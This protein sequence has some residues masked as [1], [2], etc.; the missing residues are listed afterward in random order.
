MSRVGAW[1]RERLPVSGDQLRELTNEPVPNHLKLWWFCLGGTPAYLFV[2]QIVTGILLS[3]YYESSAARAYDSVR[4][5]TEEAAFGWFLRGVH[6]WGATLMVAAV[7]LHQMRVFFTGAFRKPR[8]I[9]WMVGM[10]LLLSTLVA[11]FTGYSLVYEQLSYWGATVGANLTD[12]VP[13]VGGLLKRMLLAGDA[14][15]ERTLPRFF[16]LHAAVLP[17]T[18]ILLLGIHIAILRLQGVTEFKVPGQPEDRPKHFNFYPDHVLT[19]LLIGLFLMVVLTTLATLVPVGMGP[20][21]DPLTTPEV[22]KPEWYFYVAFRWLKLWPLGVA[23]L[24]TGFI[25][26]VMFA[27]PLVDGWIRRRWKESEA[28]VWIGL[29]AVF[30]IVGLTVWEAAV[31]H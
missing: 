9:N 15:N 1:F 27:W 26:F 5:I 31:E 10:F 8:E 19:E 28:S 3:F 30:A 17:V 24:S 20:K 6:K 13:I 23:V 16:I 21:A 4:Y 7:I 25:V 11:G 14:Y 18:M 2:V 22:I 12:N 29:A